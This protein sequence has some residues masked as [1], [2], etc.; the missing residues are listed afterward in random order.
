M[1][2][3]CACVSRIR[4]TVYPSFETRDKRFSAEVAEM[5]QDAE[6]KSRTLSMMTASL[7]LGQATIYCHV[8]VLSS[9]TEWMSG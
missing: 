1:W 8:E 2:S 5:V 9:K 6:S 3:A 4:V 7:V